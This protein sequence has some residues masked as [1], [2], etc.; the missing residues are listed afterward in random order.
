MANPNEKLTAHYWCPDSAL[1]LND[2]ALK[3]VR[4]NFNPSNLDD[5]YK[6]KLLGAAMITMAEEAAAKDP[7]LAAL[8]KTYAE[9]AAMF[10]VKL[11]TAS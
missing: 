5:V 11:L 10:L 3:Q 6:A 8:S 9:M 1:K 2:S 7:R 4:A